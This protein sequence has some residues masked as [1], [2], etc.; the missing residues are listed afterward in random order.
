MV[1]AATTTSLSNELRR[2][3]WQVQYG[4]TQVVACNDDIIMVNMLA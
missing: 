3:C 2:G 4:R 1:T